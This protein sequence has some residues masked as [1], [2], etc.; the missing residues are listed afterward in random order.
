MWVRFLPVGPVFKRKVMFNLKYAEFYITNV[1]NLNCPDCNRFN[2][3]AFKGHQRWKDHETDYQAWAKL[4]DIKTIGILGGEPLL[5]PDFPQWLDNIAK[6]WPNSEI[7]IVTNGTQWHRWPNLYEQVKQYHGRVWFD[8]SVHNEFE[9]QT[10]LE[11]TS[12]FLGHGK[13]T[14]KVFKQWLWKKQY[15]TIRGELWPDCDSVEQFNNLPEH[16][17]QECVQFHNLNI[18]DFFV[19]CNV[20]KQTSIIADQANT[21]AVIHRAWHFL[22]SAVRLDRSNNILSLHK[23]DPEKAVAVCYSKF[24]HHFIRGKLY[25]CGTVGLLPE[26]AQ[27]FSLDLDSTQTELLTSYV[28]AEHA[29]HHEALNNFLQDLIDGKSVPQCSFCPE[30]FTARYFSATTKKISL[31]RSN[32]T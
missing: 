11:N 16:I 9:Y 29:W 28:P 4:I 17:Q 22:E 6:L 10:A 2:N 13:N 26:F 8:M 20:D 24:C 32:N 30:K 3:Y 15:D 21:Y 31:Q 1:C 27:Q 25:K 19:K 14:D 23:S 18:D 5:N 12:K 7:K